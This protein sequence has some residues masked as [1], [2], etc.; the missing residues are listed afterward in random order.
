MCSNCGYLFYAGLYCYDKGKI[1]TDSGR[2]NELLNRKLTDGT[3][4]PFAVGN[5]DMS[6]QL[7]TT[8]PGF[9]LGSGLPHGIHKDDEDFK[10]GFYFDHTYGLPVIPGSS[11]K[12]KIRSAFPNYNKDM[13][14]PKYIKDIKSLWL[15]RLIENIDDENF[16]ENCYSP[17]ENLDNQMRDY[18]TELESEIFDGVRSGSSIS[19]Y[20]R[21]IFHDSVLAAGSDSMDGRILGID[22][23]TPHK[24]KTEAS[25][26]QFSDP[27][28]IKFLRLLPDVSF[29]FQF[30][31]KDSK[32]AYNGN[33]MTAQK[34]LK[35]FQ[36][37]LITEG[38]GAKTSTGY[39]Q[40]V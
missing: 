8:E 20:D 22:Y 33:F 1:R 12:G 24:H 11:V 27:N 38:L 10:I 14:T 6:F 18:I 16:I 31:L 34:K 37:I 30:D 7:T 36:K 2:L 26:D 19:M 35:L 3:D 9:I 17:A 32:I 13:S 28:P 5:P 40:L 15:I 29:D 21:D 4:S 23:C 25:L 39:G